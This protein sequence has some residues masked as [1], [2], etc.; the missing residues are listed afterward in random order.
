VINT[1]T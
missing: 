1:Y